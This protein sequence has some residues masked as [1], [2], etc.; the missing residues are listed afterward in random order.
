MI[1]L[2]GNTELLLLHT[3][4]TDAGKVG[5]RLSQDF[6]RGEYNLNHMIGKSNLIPMSLLY[7]YFARWNGTKNI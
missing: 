3:A 5:D 7:L 2:G 6:F 1:I 4:V